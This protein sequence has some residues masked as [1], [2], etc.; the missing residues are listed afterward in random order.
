LQ[1]VDRIV[2]LGVTPLVLPSIPSTVVSNQPV[3]AAPAPTLAPGATQAQQVLPTAGSQEKTKRT[4]RPGKDDK[5]SAFYKNNQMPVGDTQEHT[6]E[7]RSIAG[8]F[9]AII[10]AIIDLVRALI[11]GIMRLFS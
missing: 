10:D 6:Q 7:K 3:N 1:K 9:I 8:A 2:V 11:G 5:W 4:F